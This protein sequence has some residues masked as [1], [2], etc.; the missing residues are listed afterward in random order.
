MHKLGYKK[1]ICAEFEI[2][3]NMLRVKTGKYLS[4]EFKANKGLRQGDAIAP[5]LFHVVMETAI[6]SRKLGNHT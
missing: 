4:S 3:K 6:K 5:L 2:M 1:L